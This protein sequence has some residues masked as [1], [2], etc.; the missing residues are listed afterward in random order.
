MSSSTR[1]LT[2]EAARAAIALLAGLLLAAGMPGNAGASGAAP[3]H[4][5]RYIADARP[6]GSGRLTWFGLH[7]YDARLYV[8]AR[9]FD[10]ALLGDQ[11]FALELTYAR[12]L[13]GH[14]IAER[15]G[16]EIARLGLGSAAQRGRWL[17]EMTRLFPDVR[18]G[19]TIAGIHLP[20]AG[21]RFYLDQRPLGRID[22][23]DFGRAFFAIWFDPRTREPQLRTSL[24]KHAADTAPD[25]LRR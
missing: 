10:A 15:S 7:V 6:A 11:A 25:E 23:P 22:D 19:Q 4:V 1:W 17:R 9:G 5:A 16:D 24:L 8:P 14:A 2:A 13:D 20:G 21:T 12:P 18:P 3:P